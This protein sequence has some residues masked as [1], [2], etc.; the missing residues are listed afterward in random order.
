MKDTLCTTKKRVVKE[1]EITLEN[2]QLY[3]LDAD[4]SQK[5]LLID[6]FT[7]FLGECCTVTIVN[8]EESDDISVET[9]EQFT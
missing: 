3:Y 5:E 6:V 4:M 9:E 1:A 7:P 2:G 8:K